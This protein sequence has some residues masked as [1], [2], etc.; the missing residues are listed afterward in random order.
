MNSFKSMWE[1][2]RKEQWNGNEGYAVKL[3][4]VGGRLLFGFAFRA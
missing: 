1:K 2:K 4:S 3:S